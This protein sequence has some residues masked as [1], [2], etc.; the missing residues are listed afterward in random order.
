MG[1]SPTLKVPT[2]AT[3]TFICL[4]KMEESGVLGSGDVDGSMEMNEES[5]DSSGSGESNNRYDEEIQNLQ[6]SVSPF[7][8]V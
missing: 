5:S 6:E 1:H 4:A 2:T 8:P 3:T 7:F